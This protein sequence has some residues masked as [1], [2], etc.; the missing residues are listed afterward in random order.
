[1]YDDSEKLTLTKLSNPDQWAYCNPDQWANCNPD[2]WANDNPDQWANDNPD[3]W[4]NDNTDQWAN[5]NPD[6][7]SNRDAPQQQLS[8]SSRL[9]SPPSTGDTWQ[10]RLWK[11][12]PR[13]VSWGD[14]ALPAPSSSDLHLNTERNTSSHCLISYYTHRQKKRD[15]ALNNSFI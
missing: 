6:Q 15:S 3:Q 2:Q 14:P 13:L 12:P 10:T 1:M 4:S 5:C 7:W 11:F 9:S 8:S